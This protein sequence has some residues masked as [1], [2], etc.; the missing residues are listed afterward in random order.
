MH[1][2]ILI[3]GVLKGGQLAYNGGLTIRCVVL[4]T[5]SVH[6]TLDPRR[7]EHQKELGKFHRD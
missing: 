3:D 7:R 4:A 2:T 1:H 5:T 6:D